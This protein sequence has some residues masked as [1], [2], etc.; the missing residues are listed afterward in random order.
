M[1]AIATEGHTLNL[2]HAAMNPQLVPSPAA[3]ASQPAAPDEDHDHRRHHHGVL[4]PITTATRIV[5]VLAVTLPFVGFLATIVF[6]WGW[7]FDWV[8]LAIFSVMFASTGIG[9]TVGFHRY[10][11]HK[12]FET[13]R[14]I[15]FLLAVLGS[16]A[17]EG[18]VIKWVAQH[19]RHH[20]HSD[21]EF[22]P[23]SPH[24]HGD[25][26]LSTL[27]GFWHAHVGWL[28]QPDL[29]NFSRYIKDHLQDRM[30]RYVSQTFVFWVALGL[31]I[32]TI[33]GGLLTWSW[34]GALLG[35]LWGGLARIFFVHHITWS[36]NS[37]CHIW[38][39]QPFRSHDHSRNNVIF[40]FLAFGEGWHNS[41]HAFPTSARH[42]L[43]WWQLDISYLFIRCLS[44]LGLAWQVRV[45]RPEQLKAKLHPVRVPVPATESA[46]PI[47]PNVELP[48]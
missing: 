17:V 48:A 13:Y 16:M 37:V 41:H 14:P 46:S 40:G 39:A 10:F 4:A 45:P 34:Q 33:L 47:A 38:G 32:P 30:V 19:R 7:G 35:F 27:R 8:Q 24:V 18:P 22:D 2:H 43:F 29:R 3:D 25:T 36:I 21:D 12:S 15:Q 6:F 23:H 5:N 31:L 1:S 9:V 20:Q 42:G 26:V 28:F 44:A 11:T